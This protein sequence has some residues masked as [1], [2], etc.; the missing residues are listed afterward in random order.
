MAPLEQVGER[1]AGIGGAT[2]AS[3]NRP[4]YV[5]QPLWCAACEGAFGALGDSPA[6]K[7]RHGGPLDGGRPPC[8]LV[9][10]LVQPYA[11]HNRQ[12]ITRIDPCDTGSTR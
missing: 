7:L 4:D 8:D 1:P 5:A 6:H 3:V 9:K 11:A 12:C 10:S 2:A